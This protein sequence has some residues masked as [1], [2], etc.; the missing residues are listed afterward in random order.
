MPFN[1]LRIVS[2]HSYMWR[3]D[4]NVIVW[5]DIGVTSI[6]VIQYTSK[7]ALSV[8][9]IF[10]FI[11]NWPYYIYIN[12]IKTDK[13]N[14][15]FNCKLQWFLLALFY[16]QGMRNCQ[17]LSFTAVFSVL[18]HQGKWNWIIEGILDN[19]DHPRRR[20]C[21]RRVSWISNDTDTC[22]IKRNVV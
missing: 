10:I 7:G 21:R 2:Y 15:Y 14:K 20:F 1:H 16:Y 18:H 4:H 19:E 8:L 6:D 12:I 22:R 11:W 9:M 13:G 5:N 17:I 3:Y